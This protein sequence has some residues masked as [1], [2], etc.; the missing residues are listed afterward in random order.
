MTPPKHSYPGRLGYP[1]TTKTQEN[2]L[3]YNLIKWIEVLKEEMN[4]SLKE[5][6]ENM[7]KQIEFFKEE[8]NPVKTYR[9]IQLN[10][11][12]K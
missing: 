6:Q 12:R 7:I 5:I 8:T 11:R 4:K 9:K 3:K 1:N 2:V 10:R